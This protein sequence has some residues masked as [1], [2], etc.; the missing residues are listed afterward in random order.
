MDEYFQAVGA[1]PACFARPLA[2]IA[3]ETAAQVHEVRLRTG[4]PLWL[5]VG[6]ALRPAGRLPGC[7]PALAALRPTRQQME[8]ALYALCG[9]SVPTH[10]TELAEG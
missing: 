2:D 7:P 9:G 1:L 4:C 3:P 8:E 6:G 10:Q 5:N